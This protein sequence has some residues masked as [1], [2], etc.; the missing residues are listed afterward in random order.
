M[1]FS[2]VPIADAIDSALIALRAS[3]SQT[4]RLDAEV[5]LAHAL[6]VDRA[7]LVIDRDRPVEGLAVRRFQDLVR[8]RSVEGAPVAYL[9]G[10]RGFRR[11]DLRVDPRALIPRPETEHLVEAVLDL[12]VGA[13]VLDVG[14]GTGAVALALK[15]ERPDLVVHASDVDPGALALARENVTGL[16]LEVTLHHADLLDGVPDDLALDAVVSNPPYVAEEDRSALPASVVGHEPHVA[17]FG[18]EDGF[19]V[20]RRLVD[21]CAHRGVPCVALEHGREQRAGVVAIVRAAGYDEVV[22]HDDL[23][24][25]DRVVVARRPS[26]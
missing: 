15:D 3:G 19:A 10:H 20:I 12:P 26:P 18:G 17:L 22:T 14:T 2:G 24:G 1:A 8:R 13:T 7:R 5:L 4:P 9:V 6:G 23:A 16:G 25:I 11:L 21:Q